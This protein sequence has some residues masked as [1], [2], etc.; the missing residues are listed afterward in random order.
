MGW[1]DKQ[2]AAKSLKRILSWDFERIILAH[3][4]LIETNAKAVALQAWQPPLTGIQPEQ[5]RSPGG[6]PHGEYI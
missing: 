5:N 1:R 2:A 4:D 3:G 6:L